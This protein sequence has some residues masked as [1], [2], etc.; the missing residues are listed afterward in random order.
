MPGQRTVIVEM[1]G[2][3]ASVLV[4]ELGRLRW[5]WQI[6]VEGEGTMA[7]TIPYPNSQQAMDAAMAIIRNRARDI[8]EA[9]ENRG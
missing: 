5:S 4:T 6:S 3:S 8:S 9:S 7:S 1:Q 2:K